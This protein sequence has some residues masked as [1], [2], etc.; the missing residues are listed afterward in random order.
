MTAEFAQHSVGIPVEIAAVS[1]AHSLERCY[2]VILL[3]AVLEHLYDPRETLMRVYKALAPDGVVFID[4]PNECSLWAL[5]G[6]AYMKLRGRNWAVNLSP[7][8]PPFHVVGFCPQSLATI[9][10]DCG[11]CIAE[12]QTHRW[13]NLLHEGASGMAQVERAV[14]GAVS[15][16]GALIGKGDG[17]TCWA[18]K[19]QSADARYQSEPRA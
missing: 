16:V 4:V 3:A 10:T 9:L 8:F 13:P 6:N 19:R 11:F 1:E 2:D 12:L 5:V 15:K 17:I 14:A 18:R 7:T